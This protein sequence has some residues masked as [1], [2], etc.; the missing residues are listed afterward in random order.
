MQKLKLDKEQER[1]AMEEEHKAKVRAMEAQKAQILD[2]IK[3]LKVSNASVQKEILLTKQTDFKLKE[4]FL[5][6]QSVVKIESYKDPTKFVESARYL[7]VNDLLWLYTQLGHMI[8]KSIQEQQVMM[9]YQMQG[10]YGPMG[11]YQY[12]MMPMYSRDLYED[13]VED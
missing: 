5:K 9:P 11:G 8:N 13:D 12:P 7:S 1:E 6:K 2:D 10:M 3:K 4:D